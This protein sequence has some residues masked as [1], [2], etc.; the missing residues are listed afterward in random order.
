MEESQLLG[1]YLSQHAG[2][3]PIARTRDGKPLILDLDFSS[4]SVN[5]P[6]AGNASFSDKVNISGDEVYF[7][8]RT[9]KPLRGCSMEVGMEKVAFT[10]GKKVQ[11]SETLRRTF[12][13]PVKSTVV[14]FSI[15]P[16]QSSQTADPVAH[17]SSLVAKK[18]PKSPKS[19][20][21]V[22]LAGAT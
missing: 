15:R 1:L 3:R 16:P 22:L 11:T 8:D 14:G 7:R 9:R 13:E 4:V 19:G 17:S 6:Y 10:L 2:V 18:L 12:S 20:L 21:S 5:T